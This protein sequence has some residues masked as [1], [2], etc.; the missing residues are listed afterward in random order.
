M[1]VKKKAYLFKWVQEIPRGQATTELRS[2]RTRGQLQEGET[3]WH[4]LGRSA[5]KPV[6]THKKGF[7][8]LSPHPCSL[9][10]YS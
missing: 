1:R 6:V 2:G 8:N 10:G 5:A 3:L 9:L 4:S 7:P